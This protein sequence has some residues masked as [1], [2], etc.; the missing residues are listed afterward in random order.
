VGHVRQW[1]PAGDDDSKIRAQLYYSFAQIPAAW[2]RRWSELMSIAVRTRVEP[3]S[4]LQPL[5]IQLRG[6]LN[7]Q[8]LYQVRTL[9]E[10]D[11]ASLAQ[12]R[13]LTFLFGAF[14]TLAVL[15]ACIGI[16]GVLAYLTGQRIPE[17]GMRM[18][19]GASAGEVMWL[20][21]RNGL[22]MVL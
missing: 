9:E 15:L 2:V 8:V 7:D 17:I 1:G 13:F 5:R 21:L 20:V 3:R 12:Q 14:A 4:L 11:A 10:L 6:A 19:L 22:V 16:Y 18:A